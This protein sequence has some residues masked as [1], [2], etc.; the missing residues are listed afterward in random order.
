MMMM[1]LGSVDVA[2]HDRIE[3]PTKIHHKNRLCFNVYTN[4]TDDSCEE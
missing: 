2:K 4:L 3:G 1:F